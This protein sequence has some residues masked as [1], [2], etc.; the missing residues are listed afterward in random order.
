[1]S[2]ADIIG[3]FHKAML[4]VGIVYAGEISADGALHRF[5]ADGDHNENGWYVLHTDGL[6]AGAF[7]HYKLGIQT[8]RWCA[9][10]DDQLTRKEQGE[11]KRRTEDA[12]R[13]RD[14]DQER[15]YAEAA[16]KAQTIL[17]AAKPASDSHPYLTSKAVPAVPGVLI[18]HWP[19]RDAD[20]CLLIPFSTL[21]GVL[22]TVQAIAAQGKLIKTSN[23]DWLPGGKKSG[24]CYVMGDPEGSDTVVLGEGYATCASIYEASQ[25]PIIMTGDSG[26]LL[27]VAKQ[28]RLRWPS[29]RLLIGADDDRDTS[30][31][32]GM[33]VAHDAAQAV[34]AEVV[35]PDFTPEEI[36]SWR[37]Q[38]QGKPPTDFN[39]LRLL[40][41]LDAVRE[42]FDKA[43]S[44][45]PAIIRDDLLVR[46]DAKG[47]AGLVAHNVAAEILHRL[48]FN[49]LLYHDSI[50]EQWLEYQSSGVFKVR[51]VLSVKSAIYKSINAHSGE[52]GFSSGYESGVYQCLLREAVRETSTPGGLICFRNGVL[53]LATRKLLRHS[54]RYFFTAQMPFDWNPKAPDPTPVIDWLRETVGGH[55]DQVQLLRAWF[56]AVI[57][58][59][60][61][62]QR[63]L[64]I[65]G[66]GGSG[67]GTFTRLCV[68]M[69]GKEA[70]HTT[71]LSALENNRFETAKLF[72]KKLAVVTDAEKMVGDVSV[73]KAITGQDPLRFE[74][75]NKQTGDSFMFTGMLMVAANQHTA[76]TDYSSGIQRRRVT[77]H[78]D[79]VVP[80]EQRR[81]LEA[82][83]EPYLPSVVRWALDMPAE[84]VTDYLRGTGK[85]VSSLRE[86]RLDTLRA[87]NPIVAW[88]LDSCQFDENAATQ[89]GRREELTVTSGEE[90]RISRK[91]FAGA[92]E[93][94]YPN[95]LA[96]CLSNG[97]SPLALT[98]FSRT[99][100]DAAANLLGR[101]F[102][103]KERQGGSGATMIKGVLLKGST[104]TTY[105]SF[106]KNSEENSEEQVID[107]E[108][109]EGCE[110]LKESEDSRHSP[111]GVPSS[112][113]PGDGKSAHQ[114]SANPESFEEGSHSLHIL[115]NQGVSSHGVLTDSSQETLHTVVCVWSSESRRWIVKCA[116]PDYGDEGCRSCGAKLEDYRHG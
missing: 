18:G 90:V 81:D 75:K 2:E 71:M 68:A 5:K 57:V 79:H 73:L 42:I 98:N 25:L 53:E 116:N 21:D 46:Y 27:T 93:R 48:T 103:K 62:L 113:K 76:S 56:Q 83:F 72:G 102:V 91:E 16:A 35:A 15:R 77:L 13:K 78:F 1:M 11:L 94:L 108:Q 97:K 43:L 64:E 105:S 12:K 40:R 3:N 63:F 34:N 88:L 115:N 54:P 39:D 45:Q 61:D 20:N 44:A 109:N 89:I 10:P 19:A 84:E 47:N 50:R 85:R 66:P 65:I 30:G 69:V 60:P 6:P 110:E 114:S 92:D 51:P 100:V 74:E 28:A 104:T 55:E 37:Q 24:S 33:K 96:W 29:K 26:N 58:G 8:V 23:K 32:P 107:C 49:S 59:R 4:D 99:V 22:T 31:N 38:H 52:L 111:Y 9:K 82:E 101:K 14:Q 67:K 17:S 87:T 7:G 80:A 106:V 86:V 95:Y 112:S 70:T 41:G 36:Q